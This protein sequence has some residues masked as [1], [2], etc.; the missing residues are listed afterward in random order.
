MNVAM[1]LKLVLR[2]DNSSAVV[3]ELP[4]ASALRKQIE[5]VDPSGEQSTKVI[6]GNLKTA[7]LTVDKRSELY[8]AMPVKFTSAEIAQ[9]SQYNGAT[10]AEVYVNFMSHPDSEVRK[11]Y[12]G[13]VAISKTRSTSA[14]R[15]AKGYS[16]HQSASNAVGGKKQRRPMLKNT[17]W[18]SD[19]VI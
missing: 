6:S 10:I 4:R 7:L 16:L 11:S 2:V 3:V 17:K 14:G 9:N 19:S 1:P 18:L 13:P 8:S 15:T 5:V 12:S